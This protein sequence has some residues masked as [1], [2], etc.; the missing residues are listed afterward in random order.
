[1]MTDAAAVALSLIAARLASVPARGAMTYGL[2]RAEILNAEANGIAPLVLAGFIAYGTITRLVAPCAMPLMPPGSGTRSCSC[3]PQAACISRCAT[4]V[5][6]CAHSVHLLVTGGVL[7]RRA[8]APRRLLA[9]RRE[10]ASGRG[11][12]EPTAALSPEIRSGSRLDPG[13][14]ARCGPNRTHAVMKPR[15]PPV[16]A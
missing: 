2:G 6:S 1:M 9:T 8:L 11:G 14:A 7:P 16:L 3:F 15:R 12:T 10:A 5:M 4:A 13:R